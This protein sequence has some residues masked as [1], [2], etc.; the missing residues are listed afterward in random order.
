MPWLGAAAMLAAVAAWTDWRTREI[1]HWIVAGLAGAWILAAVR[2]PDALGFSPLAGILCGAVGLT[3]GFVLFAAGWAGG[4]DGKLLAALALW[5]GPADASAFLF[6]TIALLLLFSIYAC[7]RAGAAFRRRGIP[8]ASAF[9]P[10]AVAVLG[11][12]AG[13]M[14][15][16]L[17]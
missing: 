13:H 10:P 11:A 6:G 15:G 3:V 5:L 1:P 2:A 7:T 8:V 17:T 9:G 14:A 4:G 12:R 16:W